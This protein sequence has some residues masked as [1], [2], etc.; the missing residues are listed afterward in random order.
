MDLLRCKDCG[1]DPIECRIGQEGYMGFSIQITCTCKAGNYVRA[2]RE[3]LAADR[4]NA[5][6][7]HDSLDRQALTG[8]L[9]KR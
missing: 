4:W 1:A 7:T 2:T 3:Q 9:A 8:G 5:L 6:M